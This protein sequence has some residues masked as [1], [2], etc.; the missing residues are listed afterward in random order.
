MFRRPIFFC[1]I[2]VLV[3]AAGA[4]AQSV[5]FTDP[6]VNYSV[7]FPNTVW[8]VTL[9]PDEL[10]GQAELVYG[11]RMDGYLQIRK[12]TVETTTTPSE[13]ARDDRDNKL[14]FLPGY[15]DGKEER[16]AGTL[17][18]VMISYEYTQSGKPMVG[19]I[20]YLQ[21]DPRTIYSLRFTGLRDKLSRI[22]NQTDL[23]ARSFKLKP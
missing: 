6:N 18:G 11:D 10:R 22:R 15:V 2:F 8:R 17:S 3:A 4:S 16:F 12:E 1:A 7:E 21:A 9:R 23:I 20:Y 14:H 19:R 13:L 5:T